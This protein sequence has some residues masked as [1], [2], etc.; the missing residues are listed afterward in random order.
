MVFVDQA[1]QIAESLR[2]FGI[3]ERELVAALEYPARGADVVQVDALGVIGG[4]VSV[5]ADP[6]EL[7]I[8][9]VRTMPV[10]IDGEFCEQGSQCVVAA[11]APPQRIQ[12]GGVD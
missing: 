3:V 11:G 8:C 7:K 5:L 2:R 6:P 9:C 12:Y 10:D 4:V 1:H